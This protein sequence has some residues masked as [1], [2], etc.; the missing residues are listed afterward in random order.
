MPIAIIISTVLIPPSERRE[1]PYAQSAF[2]LFNPVEPANV[3]NVD[4]AFGRFQSLF[5]TI[6]QV[7]A[8][9]L[10]H[11]AGAQLRDRFF[12]RRG[13]CPFKPVHYLPPLFGGR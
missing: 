9:R 8:A 6:K 13:I 10:D 7:D 2:F 5:E 1:R 3:A 11:G 12:H 4:E